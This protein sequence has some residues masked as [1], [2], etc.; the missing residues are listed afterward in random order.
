MHTE[1]KKNNTGKTAL[2]KRWSKSYLLI[3]LLCFSVIGYAIGLKY[4]PESMPFA[5]VSGDDFYAPHAG[6]CVPELEF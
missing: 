6:Y 5:S 3:L 4:A 1:I 2:K